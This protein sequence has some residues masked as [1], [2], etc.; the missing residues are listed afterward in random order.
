V[1][2]QIPK[3]NLLLRQSQLVPVEFDL[4]S[5]KYK[6]FTHFFLIGIG[7]LIP[8]YNILFLIFSIVTLGS[9][10]LSKNALTICSVKSLC[11]LEGTVSE[12][13]TVLPVSGLYLVLVGLLVLSRTGYCCMDGGSLGHCHQTDRCMVSASD[14]C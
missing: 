8:K 11:P 9:Q 5:R 7:T 3:N 1:V 6:S 13:S 4:F 14:L 12:Y 2:S 10:F